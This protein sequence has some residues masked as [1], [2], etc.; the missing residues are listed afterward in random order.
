MSPQM[1][2][3]GVVQ[4]MHVGR[5][6]GR[7]SVAA[8]AVCFPMV[9]GCATIELTT[10]TLPGVTFFMWGFYSDTRETA[11]FSTNTEVVF[12][13]LCLGKDREDQ[14]ERRAISAA[15]SVHRVHWKAL[16]AEVSFNFLDEKISWDA[17]DS[18]LNFALLLEGVSVE[19]DTIVHEVFVETSECLNIRAYYFN[20]VVSGT[21]GLGVIYPQT[22]LV[23]GYFNEVCAF[24]QKNGGGAHFRPGRCSG[25]D[26]RRGRHFVD[27]HLRGGGSRSL[28]RN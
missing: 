10:A 28:G 24:A 13:L 6:P 20:A 9:N 18:G 7:S 12:G 25:F 16:A 19:L 17:A 23:C 21:D 2:M 27:L 11:H 3:R 1:L 26:T 5:T 15:E 8:E 4:G 22:A 14:S